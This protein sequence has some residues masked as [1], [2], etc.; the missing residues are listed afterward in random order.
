MGLDSLKTSQI[1]NNIQAALRPHFKSNRIISHGLIYE[2]PTANELSDALYSLLNDEISKATRPDEQNV[3][4]S[5]ARMKEMVD[6]YTKNIPPRPVCSKA[7]KNE[8]KLCV[9]LTGPTG[10][11]GSQILDTLLKDSKIGII[12]G[13]DRS[14]DARTRYLQRHEARSASNQSPDSSKIRCLRVNLTEPLLGLTTAIFNNLSEK[15]DVIIHN[16]W[17]V[18]SPQPSTSPNSP[19]TGRFQPLPPNL[20]TSNPR[21][22]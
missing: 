10:S 8:E 2:N 20:I 19:D 1:A 4:R 9:V 5:V 6:K 21:C 18:S 22:S 11:L 13:L 12:Y 16:A 14:V 7:R 15:V 3:E 17:K